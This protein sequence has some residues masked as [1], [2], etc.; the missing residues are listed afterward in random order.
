MMKRFL[1]LLATGAL[2]LI[3]STSA[4]AQTR[5]VSGGALI[6]DDLHGNALTL[7]T[8]LY[9]SPEWEAWAFEGFPSVWYAP[10]PPAN[11]AQDA[12][13]YSGP[14]PAYGTGSIDPP[15]LAYWVPP[16]VTGINN[17]GGAAGAWDYATAAALGIGGGTTLPAGTIP[18]SNGSVFVASSLTD[19][20]TTVTT[21]EQVNINGHTF[22]DPGG[23]A[24]EFD[25]TSGF[26]AFDLKFNTDNIPEGGGQFN[27]FLDGNGT[28]AM[29]VTTA[30][31]TISSL[32]TNG[33]VHATGGN[34]TLASS[35][36]V[37][38]DITPG[39]ISNGS[40]QNSSVTI[41]TGSGLSGGGPV[42]LGNSLT[43][44]NT[45][46]LSV[47]GTPNQITSSGGQNPAIG[48]SAT[49]PGQTS[50]TTLGTI[51][52]G[53]WNGTAITNANLAHSTIGITSTGTTMTVTG[54]P[55]S[56]GSS[57]NID[58]NL[59]HANTWT[60]IQTFPNLSI[61]VPELAS[62]TIGY[63]STGSTLVV[64]GAIGLGNSGNF[65]INLAHP[66]TWTAAQTF[67]AGSITNAE[68]ANSSVTVT[69]GT[70]LSG[71]GTAT[72]G[73]AAVTLTNAGVTSITGTA[74]QITASASTGAVT[75][76]LPATIN[77]NTTGNAAT[78]TTDANLTGPVTSVG[79]ATTITNNAVTYA[80]IQNES[81]GTL[82][83]NG[84]G[85]AAA[86]AEITVGSGLTLTGTTLTAT[87]S[88]GLWTGEAQLAT[89]YTNS[90]TTQ[91]SILSF[92][93]SA[94]TTYEIEGWLD[95]SS[96]NA[97]TNGVGISITSNGGGSVVSVFTSGPQNTTTYGGNGADGSG[98]LTQAN[99][100]YFQV[101]M[102][103]FLHF[104]ALVKSGTGATTIT[105]KGA[106]TST[107]NTMTVFAGSKMYYRVQ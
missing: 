86:P 35:L 4:S 67:P 44:A 78:V 12:F 80:K 41:N 102:E 106:D 100:D 43:L 84:S 8:P 28:A 79:N 69:A 38:G 75:L 6:L 63:T 88:T 101:A 27:V 9:G 107:P 45:G 37:D 59:A 66:N 25:L 97:T 81:T 29:S 24:D 55:I 68:L 42:A 103:G 56:L 72:L 82:L 70:G 23:D 60:A 11:G 49:Y 83:G 17:P 62:S 89:N 76:S 95:V 18:V 52:T 5:G 20:G 77:V 50:I 96:S 54:S 10:V 39:T 104:W 91:S 19:D 64:P 48:I 57:G 58:L 40:L 3:L 34:G 21:G 7:T 32:S 22:V 33:V 16:G 51:G 105:L 26:N 15:L 53:V 92:A 1:S 94:S 13:I 99:N 74:S 93:C 61:T 47:S 30:A 73:G 65:E 36:I 98:T 46:V 31:V 90:T 71:G 87:G 85:A 2:A 14:I